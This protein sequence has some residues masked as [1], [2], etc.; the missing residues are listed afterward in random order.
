MTE[1]R[2]RLLLAFAHP[3]DETFGMAG[4]IA[5]YA[6]EGAEVYL[7]CATNGDV[8]SADEQYLQGHE[9]VADLRLEELRCA[10]EMLGL[11]K[12]FAL[13]YRDSG[14]P[15]SEHNQH[16]DS[17]VS[18]SLDEVTER[19]AEVIRQTRPQVVVTFDPYGGYG[20]P[21]HIRMYEAT[22]RA[23]HEAADVSRFPKQI[24]SGL[25]PYQPQ[26]LYFLTFDRRWLRL[27][28]KLMPLFG[29]D[30]ERL[31]KNKDIN[32][33]V[34]A[35]H[36]YPIHAWINTRRYAKLVEEATQC[37]ASQLGGFTQSGFLQWVRQLLEPRD[38]TF[39]RAV[40][41]V[42]GRLRERDLF[43]GVRPD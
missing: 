7:I 43:E 17:L 3:D 32:L 8:G 9:T 16:P 14:M 30:P 15:G 6:D 27:I 4:A 34:I 20:H 13:G 39:M 2:R 5:R 31:G 41:P 24:A 35:E 21:D 40:P 25:D 42:N 12:L 1:P 38:D 37:H 18:A 33:R 11:K 19:I 22:S 29:L 26:K 10:V 23:F 36:Q 28:T